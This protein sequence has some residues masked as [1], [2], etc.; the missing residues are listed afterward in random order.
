MV[1]TISET[2]NPFISIQD[3]VEFAAPIL[4]ASDLYVCNLRWLLAHEY[5]VEGFSRSVIASQGA[6][7]PGLVLAEG[8]QAHVGLCAAFSK[9]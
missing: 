2:L 4:N 3:F 8:L 9:F 5:A 7:L 1:R 6:A